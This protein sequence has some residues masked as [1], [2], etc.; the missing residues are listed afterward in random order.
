[1]GSFSISAMVHSTMGKRPHFKTSNGSVAGVGQIGDFS[2]MTCTQHCKIV[3]K[4][5]MRNF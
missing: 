5:F 2:D 3:R 4:P 1:M